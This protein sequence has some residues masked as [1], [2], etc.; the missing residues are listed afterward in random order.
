MTLMMELDWELVALGVLLITWPVFFFLIK[1]QTRATNRW[2]GWRHLAFWLG[3]VGAAF[4][5][6]GLTYSDRRQL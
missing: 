1:R 6:A 2:K 4:I 3:P 5:Y